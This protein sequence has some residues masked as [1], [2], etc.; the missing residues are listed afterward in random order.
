MK[1]QTESLWPVAAVLVA[2]TWFA[3]ASIMLTWYIAQSF[4]YASTLGPHMYR[5]WYNPAAGYVWLAKIDMRCFS[6]GGHCA[7]S[8]LGFL[9]RTNVMLGSWIVGT[10]CVVVP[11]AILAGRS[12]TNKTRG[13]AVPRLDVPAAIRPPFSL[14]LGTATGKLASAGHG[15]AIRKGQLV[16]LVGDETS[17]NIVVYGGIGVGKTTRVINPLLKQCLDQDC[18]IVCF[19]VKADFGETLRALAAAAGRDVQVIGIQGRPF[20]LLGGLSP[21]IASSYIKSALLLAGNTSADATFWNE[22]ATQLSYNAL[23]ILSFLNER[24]SLAGLYQWIFV[25]S[26]RDA[27]SFEVETLYAELTR[28]AAD[29]TL[30]QNDRKKADEDRTRLRRSVDYE[31]EIFASYD[32][33]VRSGVRA[34]LSQITEMFTRAEIERAFCLPSEDNVT[35]E[36]VVDGAVFLLDLPIQRY[37]LAAKTIY[38]FVKLRFFSVVEERRLRRDWDQ[39]RSIVFVCD[40]YQ[41]VISV[42][43]DALSDLTFWDKARSAKCVGIISAQGVDSFRA[44]IGNQTLTDAVLQNF[45]QRI[46]FRT[47]DRATVETMTYLLGQVDV[48][49]ENRSTSRS[50]SSGGTGSTSRSRSASV[51]TALQSVINPQLFRTLG[52]GEALAI[53]SIGGEGYDDIIATTPLFVDPLVTAHA[54]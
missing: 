30:T 4:G 5:G 12:S 37:G 51:Q 46:C 28:R 45:R 7:A 18:G 19:D 31:E 38:T 43:K 2:T 1:K 54:S 16:R 24:Y 50:S 22:L 44:A 29:E 40:E 34:Q 52:S 13:R 8:T 47:E 21:E 14:L 25:P 41:A 42:A 27:A 36:D 15:A 39:E 26:Y 53:L 6:I 17:Q 33:K 32:E 3:S 20:N 10:I 23:V 48:E 35:L 11:L 49:R 9:Q